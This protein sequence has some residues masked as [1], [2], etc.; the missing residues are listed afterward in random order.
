MGHVQRLWIQSRISVLADTVLFYK[1]QN[2]RNDFP[3]KSASVTCP[4]F[5]SLCLLSI[6]PVASALAGSPTVACWLLPSSSSYLLCDKLQPSL[7]DQLL[8]NQLPQQH[9]LKSA[10]NGNN[11]IFKTDQTV[12]FP[13]CVFFK[14]FYPCSSALSDCLSSSLGQSFSVSENT[15]QCSSG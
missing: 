6:F 15:F 1:V 4:F 14:S 11:F 2:H 3:E 9:W 8:L 10:N 13:S 5:T 7:S 12:H